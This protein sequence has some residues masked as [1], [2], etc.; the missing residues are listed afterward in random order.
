MVVERRPLRWN[1]V[2]LA[3]PFVGFFACILVDG[4]GVSFGLWPR[5]VI[6]PN[7]APVIT[8]GVF[9]VF[10]LVAACV[11]LRRRERLW[12]LTAI[13]IVLN[14]PLALMLLVCGL[15]ILYHGLRGIL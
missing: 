4:V 1:W 13:G 14:A 10:G 9:G 15:A 7:T 11:A 12:G 2:S 5:P 3:T 8:L 6:M